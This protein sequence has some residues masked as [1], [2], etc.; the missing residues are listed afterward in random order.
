MTTSRKFIKEFKNKVDWSVIK[1][2]QNLS[3]EFKKEFN[4]VL[5]LI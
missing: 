3:E 4:Y 1:Q 5:R 2:K